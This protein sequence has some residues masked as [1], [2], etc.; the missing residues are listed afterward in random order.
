MWVV[1]LTGGI[2]SGKSTVA[3]LFA[4][5]GVAVTDTD[6]IAHQ[7]TAPGQPALQ[8]IA[9]TFGSHYLAPD[10]TLDRA[11][12]RRR[13]FS[14]PAAKR[15]LE[16]LLHP[17]IR[18]AVV[19]VIAH[20]LAGAPYRM[21]VVPLLFESRGYTALCQRT[22]VVDCPE[23]L[24][25]QRAMARSGLSEAEVRAIMATQLPRAQ[26]IALA[27]DVI[28]NDADLATLAEK[29]RLLHHDYLRLAS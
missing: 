5:L 14:D 15:T 10:G 12:L 17:L 16:A 27:D 2:G 24:Q 26:R 7:L 25:I 18:A 6:A 1:G 3:S 22:L 21:I 11:A 28:V 9:Q 29:V 13:V 23:A 19:E 4:E 8:A 20:P